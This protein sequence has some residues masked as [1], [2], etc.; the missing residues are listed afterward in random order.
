MKPVLF[1][2]GGY[3]VHSYGLMVVAAFGVALLWARRRAERHGFTLTQVT[4]VA[5][6]LLLAGVLGAR[7]GFILQE[8]PYYLS[9]KE[10]L[11]ELQFAGL[12]SYGGF[13]A[14]AV[15]LWFLT[16]RIGKSPWAMLDVMA[17]PFLLGNA[18]GRVGCLLN[19]CCYGGQCTLPWAIRIQDSHGGYIPGLYHPA[20][21]YESLM[22][23]AGI[24]ILM[25]L[26]RRGLKRGQSIAASFMLFGAGRF[27]YEF[28]RAGETSTYMG[29]LPIT[30]AQAMAAVVF[31]LGAVLFW[32]FGK[33][34]SSMGSDQ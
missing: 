16:K 24:A 34:A 19:G 1:E 7:I 9:N 26:E 18:I 29:N 2:I 13:I 3:K 22:N 5:F 21:V 27:I 4:D 11:Y 14:G 31:A 32:R 30:D 6:W 17:G 33:A 15:A 12:T 28:W 10:K 8:L 20:Q 23:L 25:L